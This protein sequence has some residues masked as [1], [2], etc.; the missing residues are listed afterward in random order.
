[1]T[2]E[3]FRRTKSLSFDQLA[4]MLGI[5]GRN[6]GRTAQRYTRH[7]RI[8]PWPMMRN[9]EAKT[10]GSVTREDFPD[11][12][13]HPAPKVAAPDSDSQTADAGAV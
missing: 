2:L 10:G 3:E 11:G 13:V 7:E 12:P 5:E 8:P 4:E 6:P 9:I 1:M